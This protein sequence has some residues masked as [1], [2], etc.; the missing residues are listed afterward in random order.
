MAEILTSDS[1]RKNES[2]KE[3]EEK[4]EMTLNYW[5]QIENLIPVLKRIYDAYKWE[6][7][8]ELEWKEG[9]VF[10]TISHA[11]GGW[12]NIWNMWHEFGLKGSEYG[13]I[14]YC[15]MEFSFDMLGSD[16]F[17]RIGSGIWYERKEKYDCKTIITSDLL[18]E[19][20]LDECIQYIIKGEKRPSIAPS[21]AK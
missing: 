3:I 10:I 18:T 12:D 19:N 20:V 17:Q 21:I 8:D 13:I 1:F 4:K 6:Y 11:K 15:S 9:D 14:V 7:K 2:W 5:K 16:D